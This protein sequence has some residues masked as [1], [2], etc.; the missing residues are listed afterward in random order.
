MTI[1]HFIKSTV[2]AAS[3]VAIAGLSL[4]TQA[5]DQ[6]KPTIASAQTRELGIVAAGAVEDNLQTCLARI[7]KDA[8]AGQRMVAEQGCKQDHATRQ[9]VQVLPRF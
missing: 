6:V 9:S 1:H 5:A 2:M 8:T 3:L 4:S 7:P